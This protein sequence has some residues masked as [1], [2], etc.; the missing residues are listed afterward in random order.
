MGVFALRASGIG[1]SA[2]ATFLIARL[3]GAQAYGDYAWAMSWVIILRLVVTLGFDKLL[4]RELAA[5]G[6][7]GA[8][9]AGRG[10]T[11]RC[12]IVVVV[13]SVAAVVAAVPVGM[14][15]SDPETNQ[16]ECL[17]VALFALP[18]VGLMAANGGALQGAGR[19]VLSR[20][21][22]DAVYSVLLLVGV[23]L[24]QTLWST[25]QDEA[26]LLTALRGVAFVGA[27]AVGLIL[28]RRSLHHHSEN[29]ERL[30][31]RGALSRDFRRDFGGL[32]KSAVPLIVVSGA[33]VFIVEFGTIAVGIFHDSAAA[34]GYA[35]CSRVAFL[36]TITEFVANQVLGPLIAR[37]YAEGKIE[38]LQRIVNR[39]T[40]G[41]LGLTGVG[42]VVLI[43]FAPQILELFGGSY[44]SSSQV[45]RILAIAWLVN[46]SA[47]PCG[48]LLI[49]TGLERDAAVGLGVAAVICIPLT[50]IL[51]GPL[52]GAG[53]A[54]AMLVCSAIWN[55]LLARAC[56]KKRGIDPTLLGIFRSPRE[57]R[58]VA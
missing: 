33:N 32:L 17:V 8:G 2:V 25:S 51:V 1:M 44:A 20:V 10:L 29:E 30:G 11:R 57:K 50:L 41:V 12:Y 28:M 14:F 9:L 45:L 34:G 35:V 7:R 43:V 27:L 31:G 52:A 19:I 5:L 39:V 16:F 36:L 24:A 6:A 48:L 56:W 58:A 49:M 47:G 55:L 23:A 26:V 13:V 21:P 53:S 40:C 18:F 37:L 54:I 15:V 4:V 38:R 22:E 42:V 3:L 46:F